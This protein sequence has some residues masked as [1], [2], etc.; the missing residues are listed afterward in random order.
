ME[1]EELDNAP[2]YSYGSWRN[3][4]NSVIDKLTGEI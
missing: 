3:Y 4:V 1:K 2:D